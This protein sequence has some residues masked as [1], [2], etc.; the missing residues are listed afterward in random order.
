MTRNEIISLAD[1][2]AS[3]TATDDEIAVFNDVFNSLQKAE[4]QPGILLNDEKGETEELLR[5][6][7]AMHIDQQPASHSIGRWR[8]VVAAAAVVTL[9]FVVT[10]SLR[11]GKEPVPVQQ[12]LATKQEQ[13][14]DI[15][16]G[17]NKAVLVLANGTSIVLDS[18]SIGA[19]ANQGGSNVIKLSDGRLRYDAGSHHQLGDPPVMLNTILTPRG[20]Q[21]QVILPDGSKVW[22]NA[23]SSLHFP[24]AFTGHERAVEITGEAYFEVVKNESMPFRVK[25][26]GATIEVLG[27]HFNINAY[28]D[29]NTVNT[30]LLEGKVKV[31]TANTSGILLP[32]AQA[33]VDKDGNMKQVK[34]VDVQQVVAWKNGFFQFADSS[35]LKMVMRQLSRWYDVE[36]EYQGAPSQSMT[37]SGKMGRDLTLKQ[38]LKILQKSEV[39]I[40]IQNRKII[41]MP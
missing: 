5:K 6:R 31:T 4:G 8:W 36:I 2:I 34:E 21:Y 24:T 38:V 11:P 10:Y 25:V 16:P 1:R 33:Q 19:I 17:G 23:V 35:S 30:T 12:Q 13:N 22:L 29:E 3:G 39:H 14:T 26:N 20:G 28:D 32:G 40:N 7:I 37:F 15:Q 9:F 41:V 18:A 27:T